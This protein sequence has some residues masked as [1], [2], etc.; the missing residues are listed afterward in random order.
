MPLLKVEVAVLEVMLSALASTPPVKVEVPVPEILMVPPKA[1]LSELE[2]APLV[3]M[4]VIVG[5]V[6]VGLLIVVS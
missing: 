5:L 2:I 6:I 1:P 4:P 3:S